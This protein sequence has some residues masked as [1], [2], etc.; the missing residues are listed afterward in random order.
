MEPAVDQAA[1]VAP[2]PTEGE[3]EAEADALTERAQSLMARITSSQHNPNPRVLHALA[4]L[5]E[6]EESRYV[7]LSFLSPSFKYS[8]LF[9]C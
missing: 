2:P 6:T 3:G 4:S 8:F 9:F 1:A 5:L 7:L